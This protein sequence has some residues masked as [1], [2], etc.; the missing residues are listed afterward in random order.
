MASPVRE[1]GSS[2]ALP[3]LI[4][5]D[6]DHTVA[7]YPNSRERG[8]VVGSIACASLDERS[9]SEYIPRGL[10]TPTLQRIPAMRKF[11]FL[12]MVIVVAAL[13]VL[14]QARSQ[15]VSKET[16]IDIEDL[17]CEACA[18]TVEESLKTVAGVATVKIDVD[19]QTATITPR[20]KMTLSARALWEALEESGFKP[21]MLV[22]PSGTFTTKPP[23]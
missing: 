6:A 13:G 11:M 16:V 9:S 19:T 8:S 15:S 20:E 4:V 14:A 7:F 5:R 17:D 1:I 10:A 12:G 22:C 23:A 21:K 18:A 2:C 3:Y